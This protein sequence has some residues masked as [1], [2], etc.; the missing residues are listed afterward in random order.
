V[1]PAEILEAM[2]AR[3]I[4]VDQDKFYETFMALDHDGSGTLDEDEFIRFYETRLGTSA[5]T[6]GPPETPRSPEL[7]VEGSW[8]S[9]EA[10]SPVP[11][12]PL[13]SQVIDELLC[14]KA[15]V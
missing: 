4:R 15:Q 11:S 1:A 3:G 13:G 10:A 8:A 14:Q 9:E 6:P 5:A 2:A 12:G 7:A